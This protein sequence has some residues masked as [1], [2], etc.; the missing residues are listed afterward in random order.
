[1][2]TFR[3]NRVALPGTYRL[4]RRFEATTIANFT[5]QDM[6]T[7]AW[8]G[9]ADTLDAAELANALLTGEV[10]QVGVYIESGTSVDLADANANVTLHFARVGTALP[11]NWFAFNYSNDVERSS[12]WLRTN[13]ACTFT[14][15]VFF[16]IPTPTADYT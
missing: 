16:D 8:F 10:K 11:L 14:V 9:A 15:E 6:R 5:E 1:M 3:G 2:S 4:V 12:F 7:A 13:G